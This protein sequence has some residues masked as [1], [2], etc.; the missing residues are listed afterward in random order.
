[1]A[2][3]GDVRQVVPDDLID[4]KGKERKGT[5]SML[6]TCMYSIMLHVIS[7]KLPENLLSQ[8]ASS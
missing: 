6:S 1:M 3:D 4:C 5:V 8:L 7:L 2:V